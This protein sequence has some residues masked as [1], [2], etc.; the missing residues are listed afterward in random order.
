MIN[1]NIMICMYIANSLS[2]ERLV[3]G[4]LFEILGSMCGEKVV[5]PVN[6]TS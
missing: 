6:V 5:N 1:S 2:I 3:E 4:T